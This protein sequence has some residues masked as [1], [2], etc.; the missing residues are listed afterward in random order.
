MP[1]KGRGG[2]PL[3]KVQAH[4]RTCPSPAVAGVARGEDGEENVSPSMDGARHHARPCERA[5]KSVYATT[6]VEL[7]LLG[8]WA[9]RA[10]A[11]AEHIASKRRL[12]CL[13]LR[14]PRVVEGTKEHIAEC[15]Y[16]RTVVEALGVLFRI[17]RQGGFVLC[18][19][20]SPY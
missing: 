2:E 4:G 5:I 18:S 1:C 8:L 14:V 6:R 15:L 20:R 11:R 17:W 13:M 10:T 19:C 7:A 9:R 12:V 3:L 16:A